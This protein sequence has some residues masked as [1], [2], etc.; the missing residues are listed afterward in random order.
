M[1]AKSTH[2]DSYELYFKG[3]DNELHKVGWAEADS[4][5]VEPKED[6][7]TFEAMKEAYEFN[8]KVDVNP[9]FLKDLRDT[10]KAYLQSRIDAIE[11][12]EDG[13]YKGIYHGD[14]MT[15]HE[16]RALYSNAMSALRAYK[17][18]YED[19]INDFYDD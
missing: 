15:Q 1:Y 7:P 17:R 2:D 4:L 5:K 3:S 18:I 9:E 12:I 11:E 13:G 14:D 16:R 6:E 8:A 10:E 19:M